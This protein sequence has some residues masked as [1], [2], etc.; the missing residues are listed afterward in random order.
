[1][2]VSGGLQVSREGHAD[3]STNGMNCP[4][5]IYKSCLSVT[6][7][8]TLLLVREKQ[9]QEQEQRFCFQNNLLS[10]HVCCLGRRAGPCPLEDWDHY[11]E[12]YH[13]MTDIAL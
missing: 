5:L 9:T 1:M 8:S 4:V 12:G 3:P 10:L 11:E 2:C 7:H 13:K 6:F